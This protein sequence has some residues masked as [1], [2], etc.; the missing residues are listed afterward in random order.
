M[1]KKLNLKNIYTSPADEYIVEVIGKWKKV[2]KK[3]IK[4]KCTSADSEFLLHKW[5]T[6]RQ[7]KKCNSFFQIWKNVASL[8]FEFLFNKCGSNRKIKNKGKK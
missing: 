4:K 1:L 3:V 7:T 6:N 2:K 5:R 8:A